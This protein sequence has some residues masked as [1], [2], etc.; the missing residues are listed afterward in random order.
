MD[1]GGRPKDRSILIVAPAFLEW[2]LG[3]YVEKLL[4]SKG[5]PCH[6]FP[7]RRA[8]DRSA[9]NRTLVEEVRRLDVD[10]VLG[11]K[12]GMIEP[13][14]VQGL[15]DRGACVILWYVDCF[16]ADV[17]PHIARLVPV[18]N[19]LL[20]TAKGMIPQYEALS[21]TPVYWIPEGVYL[22]AFPEVEVPEAQRSLYG[23][24]VAFVGNLYHP[25]VPDERLA[26]HR[27][28]LLRQVC[29][30]FDLK[31]WGVQG[32]PTTR[33]RWDDQC[34]L[35][36]WPAYHEELVKICR[37]SDIILGLNTINTVELYFS[38]RTF[39]TL[40][41]GGF[42]VTSYVP[43]LEKMFENQ[44][45]LVWYTSDSE[46]L[47]LMDYYLKRP[48]LRSAIAVAGK[49]WVRQRYGMDRQID[50]ILDIIGRHCGR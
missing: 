50:R 15:R 30:R 22:P 44:R 10:V 16:S 42:H 35:I 25:P 13:E 4:T 27:H 34:P 41:C 48:D 12:M 40:A 3:T 28:R 49:Q 31:I 39:L 37:A 24:Q 9:V 2:D 18:V 1:S 26:L 32:D 43:G 14:T 29:T 11:L 46:C 36:E 23:S 20:V 8:G 17:P 33:E 45:H 19:A 21:D 5:I 38:N 7:Y 6:R 47:E